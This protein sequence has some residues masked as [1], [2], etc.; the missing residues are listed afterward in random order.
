MNSKAWLITGATRGLGL[1]LSHWAADMGYQIYGC[2]SSADAVA[3]ARRQLGSPHAIEQVDVGDAA[4]VEQWVR[5]IFAG[6]GPC[7][8]RIINNA[9][10]ITPNSP[11]WEVSVGDFSRLIQINVCGTFHVIRAAVPCMQKRGGGVIVNLSSGWGRS[12]SPEVAPYCASKWAIEGLTQALAEELPDG[13]AAYALNPGVID[14]RMLRSCFGAG[15]DSSIKPEA[16]A[17][18][19]GPRIEKLTTRQGPIS[20]S[21]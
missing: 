11:L 13:L 7:P 6:P 1:A 14:T 9:A 10:I 4:A 2:G 3:E 15:A 5:G 20:V 16:W 21:V 19:A 17:Q 18:K 8:E 12:V